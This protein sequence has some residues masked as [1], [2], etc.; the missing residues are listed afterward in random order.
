MRFNNEYLVDTFAIYIKNL[1]T[2]ILVVETLTG[3]GYSSHL[4][5]YET[6]HLIYALPQADPRDGLH[7][8]GWKYP[9][10]QP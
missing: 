2:Y 7:F 10:D 9:I 5:Q 6:R 3:F 1:E 8:I 4:V